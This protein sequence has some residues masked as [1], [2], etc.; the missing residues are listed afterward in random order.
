M[1]HLF[2]KG[3]GLKHLLLH[4]TGMSEIGEME[5]FHIIWD[6]NILSSF[7]PKAKLLTFSSSSR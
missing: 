4:Y 2:L 3:S 5:S 6:R 7:I 1:K